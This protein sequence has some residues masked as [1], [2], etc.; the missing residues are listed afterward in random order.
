MTGGTKV[1]AHPYAFCPRFHVNRQGKRRRLSVP[2]GEEISEIEKAGGKIHLTSKPAETVPG[3]WTTG[4]V[5]RTTSFENVMSLPETD[6]LVIQVDGK[7]TDDRILDDQALWMQV[8]DAGPC[9]ITGCAHAGLIN[10]LLHVEKIGALKQVNSVVG[11]THLV[12]RSDDYLKATVAGLKQFGLKLISLCHCTGFKA[13]AT[14]WNAFPE[15]F[16]LNYSGRTIEIG[17]E[18]KPRIF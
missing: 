1:Y 13:T 8:D 16:V 5:D 11:G 7:E 4:Q 17:K 2:K 3:V 9:V 18:P 10:T 12:G 6:R 14:L 15:S